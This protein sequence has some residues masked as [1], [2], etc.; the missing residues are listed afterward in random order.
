MLAHNRR[1]GLYINLFSE[2]LKERLKAAK[3]PIKKY[4]CGKPSEMVNKFHLII[5]ISHNETEKQFELTI[6]LIEKIEKRITCEN[7]GNCENLE[8]FKELLMKI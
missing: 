3:M 2:R 7:G 8:G 5:S 4:I 1:N 6:H